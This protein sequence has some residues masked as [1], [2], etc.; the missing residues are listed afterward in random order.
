MSKVRGSAYGQRPKLTVES[1]GHVER[2][3]VRV[4]AAGSFTKGPERDPDHIHIVYWFSTVEPHDHIIF[5]NGHDVREIVANLGDE[6]EDWIGRQVVL[7]LVKRT[8]EG[9]SYEKYAVAPSFEW[10]DV[11]RPLDAPRASSPSPGPPPK[12]AR[13]TPKRKT[14]KPRG[15]RK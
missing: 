14:G 11:L 9:R 6:T 1:T 13:K 10:N 4:L 7:E 12:S 2:L 3:A 5:L 15:R 8:Y